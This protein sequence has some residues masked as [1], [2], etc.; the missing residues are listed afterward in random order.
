MQL[1]PA[2]RAQAEYRRR[3]ECQ[4]QG[5]LDMAGLHE[6]FAHQLLRGDRALVPVLLRH[7]YRGCI[8]AKSTTQ[9]IK[10]GKCEHVLVRR[11]GLDGLQ[12][13]GHDLVRALQGGAI[14]KDDGGDV[15]TLVFVRHQAPGGDAPQP[16]GQENHARKQEHA[17]NAAADH[18]GDAAG[19][20]VGDAR[21][22]LVE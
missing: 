15:I 1:E 6:Q 13:L 21:E 20:M 9:E 10:T 5:L 8:V 18:E 3:I 11:I 2:R 12:H 4:N 19:V 16:C 14:G 22:P 7:E 17:Q